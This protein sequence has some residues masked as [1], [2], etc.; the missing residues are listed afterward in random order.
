MS[1]SNHT[2]S[3]KSSS[4]RI[5]AHYARRHILF[6]APYPR[7][8]V[9]NPPITIGINGNGISSPLNLNQDHLILV[10]E[11]GFHQINAFKPVSILLLLLSSFQIK[12]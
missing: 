11:F 9:T 2:L 10:F 12:F 6:L 3:D 4:F 7:T 1:T 8:V 5:F